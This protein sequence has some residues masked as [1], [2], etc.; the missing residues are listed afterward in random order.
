M[1]LGISALSATLGL[2]FVFFVLFPVL[3]QGLIAFAI[4]QVLGERA[5]N[6]EYLARRRMRRP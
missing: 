3:V 5:E 2:V 6:Q 4:A 1:V